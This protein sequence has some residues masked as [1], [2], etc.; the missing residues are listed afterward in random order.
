[1]SATV[2]TA[3]CW[4]VLQAEEVYTGLVRRITAGFSKDGRPLDE[5]WLLRPSSVWRRGRLFLVCGRC[6][7]RCTG[8]T[9]R[10]G[11]RT[12]PVPFGSGPFARLF[13]TT[14]PIHLFGFGRR[15]PGAVDIAGVCRLVCRRNRRNLKS[16]LRKRHER[17]LD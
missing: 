17:P 7:R 4:A 13:G 8:S 9:Y 12:S 16:T 6:A 3:E 11:N 10:T 14:Q 5:S 1:M 2:R 15:N